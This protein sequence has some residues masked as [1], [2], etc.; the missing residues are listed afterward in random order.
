M[1]FEE[2]DQFFERG[3]PSLDSVV[4]QNNFIQVEK[5]SSVINETELNKSMGP[6]HYHEITGTKNE[7]ETGSERIFGL[8]Y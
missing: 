1:R 2:S 3:N 7:V 4:D 8:V 6:Q 5:I